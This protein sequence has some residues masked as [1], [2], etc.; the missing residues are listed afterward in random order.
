MS[1]QKT[2]AELEELLK[3]AQKENSELRKENNRLKNGGKVFT[4]TYKFTL[5]DCSIAYLNELKAKTKFSGEVFIERGG[6]II[7]QTTR[8]WKD[9]NRIVIYEDVTPKKPKLYD[10]S[11]LI[12]IEFYDVAAQPPF[13]EDELL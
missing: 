11:P 8:E 4:Y 13:V 12:K 10:K 3:A 7:S 6:S 9:G 5:A 2:K 1:K